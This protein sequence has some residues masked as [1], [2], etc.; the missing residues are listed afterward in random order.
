MLMR[1]SQQMFM[2]NSCKSKVETLPEVLKL[3]WRSVARLMAKHKSSQ[4]L[5][6][7]TI[8]D[9]STHT[10]GIRLLVG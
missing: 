6:V 5:M 4:T 9:S 8:F 1:N 3:R 10:D 2:A 7:H